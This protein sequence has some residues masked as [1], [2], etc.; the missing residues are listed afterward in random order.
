MSEVAG[1]TFA[2]ILNRWNERGRNSGSDT[3]TVPKRQRAAP[4]KSPPDGKRVV[5]FA[6]A[7]VARAELAAGKEM[8]EQHFRVARSRFNGALRWGAS[9]EW[10]GRT[11]A[12]DLRVFVGLLRIARAAKRY[13][14]NASHRRIA[15]VA[16]VNFKTVGAA[17]KRLQAAGCPVQLTDGGRGRWVTRAD[18]GVGSEW[19]IRGVF[20][21]ADVDAS[22]I[23][24]LERGL[25]QLAVRMTTPAGERLD[26]S[27]DAH[28][29]GGVCPFV[30]RALDTFGHTAK[31][32]AGRVGVTVPAVR[33]RLRKLER[34]GL[35][36]RLR[37]EP[38]R[39]AVWVRG[40]A[41]VKD[42]RSQLRT[43][44]RTALQRE[45]HDIQRRGWVGEQR[46]WLAAEAA[47]RDAARE[48]RAEAHYNAH[49]RQ[50]A[51]FVPKRRTQKRSKAR[52]DTGTALPTHAT[53][54]KFGDA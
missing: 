5:S 19:E 40:A 45:R 15:E 47:K 3:T 1:N 18:T 26:L 39:A 50:A 38:G 4:G 23:S 52:T 46:K 8:D 10:T 41:D 28:R 32:L 17:L 30:L 33:A 14:F 53:S 31:E 25:V 16:G 13:R 37:S 24:L 36:A 22:R 51:R 21:G 7:A 44:G 42:V 49:F 48:R 54:T 27:D 12:T 35:A 6:D 2:G 29:R 9:R 20:L 11:G 34:V 43:A